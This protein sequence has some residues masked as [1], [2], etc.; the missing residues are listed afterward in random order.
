LIEVGYIKGINRKLAAI[1]KEDA[2]CFSFVAYMR[3]LS[4]QFEIEKMK[5]FLKEVT[6]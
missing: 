6:T 2:Q 4:N 5:T 3:Q 1:E